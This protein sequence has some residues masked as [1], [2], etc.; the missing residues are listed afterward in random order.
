MQG[1]KEE[2]QFKGRRIFNKV[3]ELIHGSLSERPADPLEATLLPETGMVPKL[4]SVP[5]LL[6]RSLQSFISLWF[7]PMQIQDLLK[8]VSVVVSKFPWS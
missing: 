2:S 7:S 3:M 8:V 1:F 4:V 5:A 6:F